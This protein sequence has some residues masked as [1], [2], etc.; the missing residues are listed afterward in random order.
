MMNHPKHLSIN[1]PFEGSLNSKII[2]DAASLR[3][4]QAIG[5]QRYDDVEFKKPAKKKLSKIVL[6]G[7]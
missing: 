3:F 6:L 5:N 2:L 7:S 4:A 1:D